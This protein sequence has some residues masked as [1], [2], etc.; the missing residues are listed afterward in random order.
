MYI[1]I[2]LIITSSG[3]ITP[4]WRFQLKQ[5]RVLIIHKNATPF[6]LADYLSLSVNGAQLQNKY[7]NQCT[8]TEE[9]YDRTSS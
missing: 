4:V 5:V 8:Q 6:S 1:F 7:S 2:F 3:L 9:I